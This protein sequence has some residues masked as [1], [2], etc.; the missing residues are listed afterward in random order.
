MSGEHI[1]EWCGPACIR[2]G[3]TAEEAAGAP[4]PAYEPDAFL[5]RRDDVWAALEKAAQQ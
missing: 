3:R 5:D 1:W 4:C 2:C